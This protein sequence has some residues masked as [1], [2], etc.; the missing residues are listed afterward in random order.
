MDMGNMHKKLGKNHACGS[1]DYPHGQTDTQTGILI[2]VLHNCSCR[3]SN[4][5]C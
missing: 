4:G 2:T 3:R 1:R 5:T